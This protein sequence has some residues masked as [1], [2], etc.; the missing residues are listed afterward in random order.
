M[1]ADDGQET[2]P[3]SHPAFPVHIRQLEDPGL[4]PDL[5]NLKDLSLARFR[6]ALQG[7][8]GEIVESTTLEVLKLLQKNGRGVARES[9]PVPLRKEGLECQT[10]TL[11]NGIQA[12]QGRGSIESL[13]P[14]LPHIRQRAHENE[15]RRGFPQGEM[16]MLAVDEIL[17]EEGYLGDAFR[18]RNPLQIAGLLFTTPSFL[19]IASPDNFHAYTVVPLQASANPA[20]FAE[21]I[22]SRRGG[23]S[24]LSP[25]QFLDLTINK[26]PRENHVVYMLKGRQT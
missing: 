23:G 13:I 22:D 21:R 10:M 6:Q 8:H 14:R 1:S 17:Q 25:A 26:N 3:Q 20:E 5:S 2:Y 12:W 4:N 24:T 16:M 18:D 7:P 11:L 9:L 19:G 15:A